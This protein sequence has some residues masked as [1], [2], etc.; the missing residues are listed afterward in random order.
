MKKLLFLV[1]VSLFMQ[2]VSFALTDKE[3]FD[4]GV[5]LFKQS[6][7]Q[8][9]IDHFS[10]LI[11][12]APE[13]A[14][15]YKNRGVSYMKLEKF[16]LAI[17]DFETARKIFPEL[18]GLYSNLGVAWY[19]KKNYKKAIE[20]YDME[21][22]MAPENSIAYFNRA[23][24]LAELNQDQQ[25][26]EDLNRTLEL[27][28]DFYWAI[29]YKADLLDKMGRPGEAEKAYQQAIALGTQN[30]YAKEKLSEL[31]KRMALP[32]VTKPLSPPAKTVQEQ[33]SA[34]FSIQA[35]A[36]LN[37]D[38]AKRMK[39]RLDRNGFKSRVM[40]LTGNKSR[41]WYV[42]RSG[43]FSDRKTANTVMAQMKGKMKIDFVIRPAEEW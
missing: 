10:R 33:T 37:P 34:V 13:N 6:E 2:T 31:E 21:I 25:A 43:R 41:N 7:Y 28:P 8:K 40:I 23:L 9:A 1:M 4:K 27:K 15:A 26:L 32:P 30:S 19:Y 5:Q 22:R 36:F 11:E 17:S 39:A 14:D 20:N 16:D 42:V 3:L 35:G 29:C 24:C 38:N 12:Q 18:K